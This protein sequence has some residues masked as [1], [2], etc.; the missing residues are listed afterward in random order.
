LECGASPLYDRRGASIIN[1]PDISNQEPITIIGAGPS[2]LFCS[3]LLLKAGLKVEL[4]D[5]MSGVGKKFLVAGNGGLNLTH[6]ESL[7]TF[8]KKYGEHE[9]F[10]KKLLEEFSPT[11]LREWCKVL[12]VETFVGT[13]GRVFPKE[14]N[15]AQMIITWQKILKE[16]INFKLFLKHKLTTLEVDG[17][18]T[19]ENL[20]EVKSLKRENIILCLGGAS[21]SKTGSDGLW[22]K[23]LEKLN[24]KLTEFSAMN[25]GFNSNWSIRFKEEFESEYIKNITLT[26]GK[27]KVSGEVMLT[28][29]G[30]EGGAV[31]ALSKSI[32]DAISRNEKAVVAID[33]KPNLSLEDLKN[34]LKKPRGK[35]SM[36]NHLRKVLN[37]KGISFKLLKELTSKEDFENIESLSK[38]IKSLKITLSSA[39][40]IDEAISTSGGVQF[41]NLDSDLKLKDSESIYLIG[42][43]LDWEAPTGGYLLQG[44]FSQA[45]HTSNV[46][47]AKK[48]GP[49]A[50]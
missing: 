12:G 2:G 15:A 42:E 40:P 49:K 50:L 18:L 48:K 21:W 38:K 9:E 32:N 29:Y 24:L 28:T 30:I 17:N 27:Q 19:F 10:F 20:G 1:S 11:D 25:C 35:N 37:L 23:Y 43:M 7:D 47:I 8:S 13:S 3:Y 34:K 5:Q 36:S 16:N 33:L 45:F 39:R 14:L 41:S 6:S 44:C 46:I 22:T 26:H 4:Y 31:Y